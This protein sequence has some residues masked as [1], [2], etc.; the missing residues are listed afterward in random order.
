MHFNII[1]PLALR[2][3]KRFLPPSLPIAPLILNLSI[4]GSVTPG[5]RAFG[6]HSTAVWEVPRVGLDAAVAKR[7]TLPLS[8]RPPGSGS[9]SLY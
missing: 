7:K 3:P 6:N 1:L 8:G 2:S 5:E 4:R 9:Q